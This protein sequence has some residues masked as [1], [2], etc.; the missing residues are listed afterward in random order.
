M[1]INQD[2]RIF[3]VDRV[4]IVTLD[5][6]DDRP[7]RF[8]MQPVPVLTDRSPDEPSPPA[9]PAPFEDDLANATWEDAEWQ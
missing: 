3:A 7:T 4:V 6:G 1:H 5:R 2:G 9:G 8:I